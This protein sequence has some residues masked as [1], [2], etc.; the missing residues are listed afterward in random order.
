MKKYGKEELRNLK[1]TIKS[2]NLFYNKG[3]MTGKLLKTIRKFFGIKYAAVMSSGTAAIHCAVAALEIPPGGEVIT[4]PITDM[5]TV[6][7]ILYQNLIPIFADVDPHTYNITAESIEKVITENTKAI[8]VVHLTGNPAEMNEIL[9]LGKS[10]G[11]PVIEDCAQAYGGKYKNKKLGTMGDIGCYSLNAYKHISAGDGGFVITNNETYYERVSNYADKYYDRHG[12]GVRLSKLAPNYR[13]TELQSA[14]ALAQ[15]SKL[16]NI[17]EKRHLFGNMF[18][19]GIMGLDGIY[20]HKVYDYNYASYW[21]TMIR[22]DPD[23]LGCDRDKFV[24]KLKTSGLIKAGAGYIP[25]PI[26]L[27]PLFVNKHF[28]PGN[29]WPAEKIGE[30]TYNYQE[31]MCPIAEEILETAIRIPIDESMDE[32]KVEKMI[33]SVKKAHSKC[34]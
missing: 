1:K 32:S 13:I 20:P 2:D 6:I 26:Y 18:N 19:K 10:R 11:I 24:R 25:R 22:M 5:G 7:G 15:F 17:V 29:I 21:F 31:G 4:A 3:K 14:V 30:K 33:E 27:E 23:V 9:Q 34:M 16:S 12:K 28:F 8:L